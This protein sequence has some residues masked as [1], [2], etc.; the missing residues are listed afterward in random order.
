MLTPN[1]F[2]DDEFIESKSPT[3]SISHQRK[4]LEM[5]KINPLLTEEETIQI[6]KIY[7]SAIDRLLKENGKDF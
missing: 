3:I 2:S 6:A 5:Q 1:Y 4:L 7:L